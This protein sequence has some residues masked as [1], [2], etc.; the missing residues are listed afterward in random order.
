MSGDRPR[1]GDES[2]HWYV[3]KST[4]TRLSFRPNPDELVVT[5]TGSAGPETIA[6]LVASPQVRSLSRGANPVRGFAA[7]HPPR[8]YGP[9]T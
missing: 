6:D 2:E 9:R 7:I 3:D 5:F 1:V 8:T 4:G